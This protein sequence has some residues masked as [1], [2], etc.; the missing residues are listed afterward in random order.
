MDNE[1]FYKDVLLGK[2]DP[3]EESF[4]L[5]YRGKTAVLLQMNKNWNLRVKQELYKYSNEM[6][7]TQLC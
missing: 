2:N 1:A 3:G 6:K 7:V 5:Y 4:L